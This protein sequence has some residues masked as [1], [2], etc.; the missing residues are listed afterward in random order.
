MAFEKVRAY[1]YMADTKEDLNLIKDFKIGVECYVIQEA[2][3]YKR[4]SN[5][6]WIKQISKTSSGSGEDIGT[7]LIKYATKDYVDKNI[8]SLS[9]SLLEIA[10]KYVDDAIAN[11]P[12]ASEE[13][14]GLVKIDGDT[15][16]TNE[17]KQ[18][19]IAKVS[20][21]LLEQGDQELVLNGGSASI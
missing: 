5:G 2:C 1:Q 14:F 3:E 13:T 21:D 16:K 19:Y 8:N 4:M 20:T 17:S 7:I 18:L 9:D 15:L 6:D 10:K 11:L 12:E